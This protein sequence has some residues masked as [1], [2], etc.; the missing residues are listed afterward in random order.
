[1][2]TDPPVIAPFYMCRH[3]WSLSFAMLFFCCCC[4]LPAALLLPAGDWGRSSIGAF[5]SE[6]IDLFLFY[7][8]YISFATVT[9]I[10]SFC[11]LF[12]FSASFLPAIF[13]TYMYS[14]SFAR[15]LISPFSRRYSFSSMLL[16]LTA[17]HVG[18]C[19]GEIVALIYPC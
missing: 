10:P 12:H 5:T 19:R 7:F 18:G 2:A 4:Y 15:L 6:N 1:M 9:L 11:C 3:D 14:R 16:G 17:Y 13:C 8:F